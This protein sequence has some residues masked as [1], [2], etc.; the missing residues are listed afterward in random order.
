MEQARKETGKGRRRALWAAVAVIA[1]A[2]AGVTGGKIVLERK[3]N[4]L[5]AQRGGKAGSVEVDF[6][7]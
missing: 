6:L 2:A 4:E 5:V 1:I 7:G 3:V